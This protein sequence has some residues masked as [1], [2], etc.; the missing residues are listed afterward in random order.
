[1]EIINFLEKIIVATV[2][3]LN[4]LLWGDFINLQFGETTIGLSIMV[5]ILLPVGIFFTFKT[6]F[7]PFRLFPEMIKV[8]LEPKHSNDEK[9][10]SGLQALIVATACRVGMGNLAGVAAAISFGG[11]GAVFWMWVVALFGA[12]TAFI[13]STLAQIYKEKDPLYGGFKGGPSYYISRMRLMTEVRTSDLCVEDNLDEADVASTRF[14]T[15]FRQSCSFRGIAI[16]F[17][18]SGLICWAGIS[19]IVANSVSQ[20]FVNAFNIPV[21]HTTIALVVIS[22][23]II[24]K[25]NTVVSILDKVVPVMACLYLLLTIFIMVKNIGAIPTMFK[26]II[27]QAF[28]IKQVVS[29]GFGAVLMNGVKRGLFS[30]E[31][32]S[33]SAPNAAAAADVSHP[34]KQGLIQS[35]GVFID[36]LF[37]C[38]CSAFIILLAPKSVTDG[39]MGMDLLQSAMNYH[40][41]EIGVIFIAVILFLFS[42][43]TFLG[44]MFYSRS[45]LS[46]LF[47]DK[48]WPQ[49]TYKAIG[50]VMLFFGGIA[51]YNWVW[52]LGDLGVALMTVF[53]MMALLPLGNQA[54]AS[55]KDYE[56]KYLKK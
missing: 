1:M 13:E 7:L 41:G 14:G 30:N 33:G 53:N 46:F 27:S 25:K 56:K 12:A 28:G 15:H 34:A 2:M 37:I 36:T 20:S 10:I 22:G 51:Q 39:L 38:S 45:I 54:I 4:K 52:E 50:L 42:F 29:G 47:G 23:I 35:F 49:N 21:L 16:L 44:V 6:K 32:G 11:A 8:T 18:L 40:I 24:F 26:E 43:S 3:S 55:L 5:L 17:S 31:A 19:Q 48:W 9:S